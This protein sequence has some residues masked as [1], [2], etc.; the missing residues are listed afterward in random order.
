MTNGVQDLAKSMNEIVLS[1]GELSNGTKEITAALNE[2]IKI[3]YEVKNES[4]DINSKSLDI[5]DSIN[6]VVHISSNNANSLS[7]I[8]IGMAQ[9]LEST[10]NVSS[11]GSE[12]SNNI[13]IIVEDISKINIIDTSALL[14]SD[15]HTLIPWNRKQ[16]VIPPR[17]EKDP[18]QYPEE[19][20]RHWYDMEYNGW[21][22]TEKINIPDSPG[23]G[24]FGKKIICLRTIH[25]YH[26]AYEKGM[27]K[28]AEAFGI[29]LKTYAS[30]FFSGIQEKQ[31]IMAIN[32]KPDMII[33]SPDDPAKCI[34]SCKK[35]N[36]AGIPV[37]LSN[38]IPADDEGYKYIICWTGPDDWGQCRILAKKFAEFMNYKGN[39]CC[40]R[41]FK[42]T[43]NYIARTYS[44]I[45]ELKKIAPEMKCLDMK[46]ADMDGQKSKEIVLEWSNK[47][48]I[49]S[50]DDSQSL[51]GANNAIAQENREDI[52]RVGVCH[53]KTGLDGV[54]SGK[55]NAL[56][57][58]SAEGDGALAIEAAINWFNGLDIIPI[59]YLLIDVITMENIDS[60]YPAQW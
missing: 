49:I 59:K 41:H 17:P 5:H 44:F 54:K 13:N 46:S 11:L 28:I 16:K 39:Y 47:F 24:S 14:S 6:K 38:V 32:E 19:D 42:G 15:G 50:A 12:N 8:N 27:N 25:P 7:E 21:N 56:T 29:S 51:I 35:I 40:I 60:F 26:A 57:F 33:I 1:L 4:K 22:I 43:S 37:I 45:T 10:S 36:K 52:I 48:G 53:S 18:K 9:I 20:E 58:Q 3:T 55:I 31:V 30:E 34:E 23:D 2:L